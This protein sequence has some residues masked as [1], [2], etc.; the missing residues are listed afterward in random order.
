M[1]KITYSALLFLIATSAQALPDDARVPVLTYHSW[2]TRYD[3]ETKICDIESRALARDLKVIFEEG[4][5]VIPAYWLVEWVRGWRDG[6][7]LPDKAVV[8]TMDDGYDLDFLDNVNPHHPCAPL[9]SMRAVLEEASAWP[10]EA[11]DGMPVP[12]VTTFVISS[13]AARALINPDRAMQDNWWPS[14]NA[15]PLM[16]VQNHGLDHDHEA[17]PAG[18]LDLLLTDALG[19]DLPVMLPAGG[20]EPQ[21]TS[22]RIDTLAESSDYVGLSAEYIYARAGLWPDL[23]AYP[24]GPASDYMINTYMPNYFSDHGSVAAYCAGGVY[25]T[26]DSNPYCLGR[27]VHRSSPAYGGWRTAEELK[28]IL[29]QAR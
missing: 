11:P 12:H 6:S 27:F 26:R 28:M 14:A 22:L 25:V 23:L 16:E 3:A 21:M 18:T 7:T 4:Y 9:R 29:R 8:I 1:K 5:T 15:H 17:I 24:F 10:W 2:E 13:P 19:L 20:G